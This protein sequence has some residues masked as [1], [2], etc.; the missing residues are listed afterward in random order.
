VVKTDGRPAETTS[1]QIDGWW[2]TGRTGQGPRAWKR[3]CAGAR[4]TRAAER[5]HQA[6]TFSNRNGSR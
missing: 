3:V 2:M 6:R 4:I 1:E 5:F